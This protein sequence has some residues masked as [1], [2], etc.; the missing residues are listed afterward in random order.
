[1]FVVSDDA[2]SILPK[3]AAIILGVL[4]L[5]LWS[6][7]MITNMADLNMQQ[8]ERMEII[9][10]HKHQ[11]I[12]LNIIEPIKHQAVFFTDFNHITTLTD[13]YKDFAV[14]YDLKSVKEC[15]TKDAIMIN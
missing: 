5:S 8:N 9:N 12:C 1:M 15:P 7:M 2:L 11:N 13:Y 4:T 6:V 3:K 14:Y 10:T